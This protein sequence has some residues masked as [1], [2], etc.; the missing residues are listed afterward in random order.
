M[1]FR[2]M[3]KDPDGVWESVREAAEA[4]MK[5]VPAIDGRERED[6]IE[7]RVEK[8]FDVCG[9]WL[10]YKEYLT[11]EVDTDQGTCVVVENGK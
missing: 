4:S 5:D 3:L 2:I 1:K 11:V 7:G 10:E 6:L 9:R 8:L